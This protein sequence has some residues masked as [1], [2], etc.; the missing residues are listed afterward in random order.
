M[1]ASQ[2]GAQPREAVGP[3]YVIEDLRAAQALSWQ[4]LDRI[5]ALIRPGMRESEANAVGLAILEELGMERS[6]HPLLIRFGSNTLKIFSDRSQGDTVLAENDIF[7]IDMG[8]VFLGHEG[9]VGATYTVGDDPEM[10]ACAEAVRTL[11]DRVR[12]IWDGGAVSGRA[13]YERAEEEARAMG[14]VL[15]L[16]IR[17][18]RVSDY[19]HSVHKGGNLGD[20]DAVPGT[21]L[22]ILEMQIRHP[23][24]PFGAF[25]EDLLA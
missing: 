2:T 14:W 15:N 6:W 13:L 22:W 7:F 10:Q 1:S 3:N 9:D 12:A 17:G 5:A 25:H 8:P 20:F 11:F 18:H 23:T 21:G 19:P 16:D 24:R 4:A